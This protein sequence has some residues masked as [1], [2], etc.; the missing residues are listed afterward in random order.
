M[1]LLEMVQIAHQDTKEQLQRRVQGMTLLNQVTALIASAQDVAEALHNV[2]AEL[3][4]FLQVPQAGF[5]ILNP[6]HTTAKV[7]A[8]YHPPGS[9]SAIGI[10]TSV[11]DSPSI[12]YILKHKTPLS[13]TEAQA[14]PLL[15]PMHDFIRQR[16]VQSILVVPILVEGEVIGTLGIDTF[17]KRAFSQA[18]VELVQHVANQMG[19]LLMWKQA[20]GAL[21]ESEARYRSLTDDVLDI[22]VIGIFILD[23]DFK[24][25]WVNQAL[26]RYFGVRREEII[27]KDKRQ[28]I[29]K[30]IRHIFE[31]PGRFTDK[32]FATYDDNTYV[33]TFECH[34]LPDGERQERWLEHWSQPIRSGLYAG[35]RIE[36]YAD[37][38][39][40]K[41]A[42]KDINQ[43]NRELAILN[44][45][46]AVVSQSLNLD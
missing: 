43:R 10:T 34:V 36:H 1:R 8:D 17:Q 39:K 9:P 6:E 19:P 21:Q 46:A 28:L 30:R 14:D 26:E 38:T 44:A 4:R 40:R 16:N 12:T 15:A 13:I 20:E 3:A 37:I 22:S 23:S 42:E 33:E 2:C 32:V 45:T 18:D 5:A 41:R 31:N 7:I 24:V 11:D 35:G 27:G 29:R 25:V